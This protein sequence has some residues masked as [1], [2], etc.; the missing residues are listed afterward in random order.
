[1]AGI[2]A[3]ASG[4]VIAIASVIG[5]ETGTGTVA[6]SGTEIRMLV[7]ETTATMLAT[8]Q[9][10]AIVGCSIRSFY[11]MPQVFLHDFLHYNRGATYVPLNDETPRPGR[12][13]IFLQEP[14]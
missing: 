12:T 6:R 4:T 1:M 13:A 5:I 10:V 7:I 3:K 8:D 9:G 11:L 2:A 14:G